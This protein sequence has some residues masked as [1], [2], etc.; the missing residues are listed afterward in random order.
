MANFYQDKE[1]QN[2]RS[3]EKKSNSWPVPPTT[4]CYQEGIFKLLNLC[5]KKRAKSDAYKYIA[6][7]RGK[8]IPRL[9]AIMASNTETVESR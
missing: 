2:Q 6:F 5:E 1:C 7:W 3:E 8:R 4:N 9:F